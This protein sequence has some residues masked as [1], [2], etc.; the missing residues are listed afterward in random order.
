MSFIITEG[1][2]T[3]ESANSNF[4]SRLDKSMYFMLRGCVFFIVVHFSLSAGER[5]VMKNNDPKSCFSRDNLSLNASNRT[6]HGW[7]SLSEVNTME[8]YDKTPELSFLTAPVNR[9]SPEFR[10]YPPQKGLHVLKQLGRG[11]IKMF[12]DADGMSTAQV[13][14]LRERYEDRTK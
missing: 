3:T 1:R 8:F 5:C 12:L 6:S 2:D 10:I 11:R 4:R 7:L 9:N 14:A 13:H